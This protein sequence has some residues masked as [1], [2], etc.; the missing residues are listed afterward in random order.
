M[1]LKDQCKKYKRILRFYLIKAIVDEIM[2]KPVT[3]LPKIKRLLMK[4]FPLLFKKEMGRAATLLPPEFNAE[5]EQI[6]TGMA[7]N[8]ISTLLEVFCYEKLIENDP[9]FIKIEGLENLQNAYEK[10]GT[11]VILS[12]HFGNWEIISYTLAK[13]GYKMNV[14]ARPQA[15]NQMTRLMNSFREK[16]GIEVVMEN[17]IAESIKRLH[18]GE[19]V[20][21]LSDLNAREW[22]YQTEFFGRAASFYSAPVILSVRGRAPLIPSFSERQKDGSHILRFEE[23]IEWEKGESM[24]ARIHKYVIRY[25]NEFRRRPDQ[26]C[27]FHERYEHFDLGKKPK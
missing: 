2:R 26:W 24:L 19:I 3:I 12:A 6:I 10:H 15:E 23:P 11:F 18:K 4:I 22:G 20:G 9:K 27:W 13:M 1:T 8:Q 25:E 14:I 7:N 21:L 16:R 5:K 17:N